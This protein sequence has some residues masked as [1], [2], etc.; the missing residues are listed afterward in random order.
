MF[1]MC[2]FGKHKWTG[3]KCSD[4]GKNRNE[5]HAW[6]KDC[7]K[8]EQC[9]TA[10]QDAH[11]WNGSKCSVCGKTR[12]EETIVGLIERIGHADGP[13]AGSAAAKLG[14]LLGAEAVGP[15]LSAAKLPRQDIDARVCIAAIVFSLEKIGRP[16]VPALVK[17][18]NG[19]IVNNEIPMACALAALKKIRGDEADLAVKS[20]M[21][22]VNETMN[23]R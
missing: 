1:L 18:L 5:G 17:V 6:S 10:R 20:F 11:K 22:R 16:A 14:A 19:S 3:C 21:T 23:M 4:C 8:C 9:G 2:L 15:L 12:D 13:T 7:E